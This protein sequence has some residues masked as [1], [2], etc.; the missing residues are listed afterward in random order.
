[1]STAAGAG[2]FITLEGIEGAGKSTV[3]RTL[4]LEVERRGAAGVLHT[5]GKGPP[6][7][8]WLHGE[9]DQLVERHSGLWLEDKGATLALHYRAAPGQ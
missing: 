1:M 8:G 6:G 7:F 2:A 5:H 3:A 9:L 4:Q